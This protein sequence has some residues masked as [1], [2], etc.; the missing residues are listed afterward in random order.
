M[1]PLKTKLRYLIIALITIVKISRIEING[2]KNSLV[3]GI[4]F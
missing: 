2:T 1:V 4:N 3:K